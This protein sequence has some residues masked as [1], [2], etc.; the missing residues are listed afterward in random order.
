MSSLPHSFRESGSPRFLGL[1]L[2]PLGRDLLVAWRGMLEWPALSWL[3]PQSTVCLYLPLGGRAVSTRLDTAATA[4]DKRADAARLVAV[5]LPEDLLLRRA[6][7][8]PA[9]QPAELQAAIALEVQTL[10]PFAPGDAIWAHEVSAKEGSTLQVALVL[11]SRKLI[12]QYLA[13]VHP[14]RLAQNP[15]VWVARTGA[16]GYMVLPGFGEHRRARQ[17][18]LGRWSSGLL[19]LLALS[20]LAAICITPSAQLYWRALQAKEAMLVLQKKAAPVMAQRQTLLQTT[21]QLAKLKELAGKP[22]SP[23]QIL[24]LV[25]EALPDDTSLLSLQIQGFKVSINGQTANASALMKS[26][27]STPALRDVKAP[28]PATKPLGAPRE[29]FN[30]EFTVDPG[31]MKA[32]P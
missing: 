28:T 10:S 31:Q 5:Q 21:E 26:L 12:A 6:L 3:W 30:I 25:T 15:E 1:N 19:A 14:Q 4:D 13:A 17:S 16:P 32:E 27:G 11:C 7:N 8:L 20:V 9:L 22:V 29:T 24:N 2:A 23:L 18:V